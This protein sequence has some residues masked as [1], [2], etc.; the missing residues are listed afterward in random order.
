MTTEADDRELT[1]RL[2][3]DND[4]IV[5]VGLSTDPAKEAHAV[6][7]Q[8]QRRGWR[9]IPVHPSA[10]EILGERAYR[11]VQ[12]I[13]FPVG[14]VN[15]FRPSE[16]TPAVARDAVAA[17]ASALWLQEGISSAEAREIAEG[18]GLDYVE[19]QCIAVARARFGLDRSAG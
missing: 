12:E 17:G 8:M 2:L 4:T 19:D 5:V 6:P 15:V 13:P 18:A 14:L 9:I 1:E 10:A 3:V 7:A 11:S 16:Q